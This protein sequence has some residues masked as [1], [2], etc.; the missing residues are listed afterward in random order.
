MFICEGLPVAIL[1]IAAYW[2]LADRP[3]QADWLSEEERRAIVARIAAE[4][5]ER[6]RRDLRTAIGDPRVLVCAGVQLGFTIGSYGV[7][8]WL[9][10]I[11]KTQQLGNLAVGFI[12]AGPY[13][14][15]SIAMILWA[16]RVGRTGRKIG[17]LTL[18][19]FIGAA[20]L[21][22]AI[23]FENFWVSFAWITVG[24]IGITTARAIFW[25]IPPRFLTGM[26][27]AGG[28]AFINSIGTLGG[29]VGPY[30]VGWLKDATGNFSAGLLAMAGFLFAS[31]VLA[32]SLK[33]FVR[34][35]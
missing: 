3:E 12:T 25:T 22:L 26:A 14:L 29:F 13:V 33:R 8:I 6:E 32:L 17:S 4:P 35:E 27:A 20:G 28:L 7:G 19:C 16:V 10:Q 2:V 15:A 34:Q 23:W 24:L 1:G 11:I 9:P 5:R 31:T 30:V 18:T 21:L